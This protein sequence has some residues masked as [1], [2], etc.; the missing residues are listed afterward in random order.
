MK[1]RAAVFTGAGKP[2]EIREFPVSDPGPGAIIVRITTANICGSDLH[3]WKGETVL[4]LGPGPWILGHEMTGRI[5]R[6]GEGVKTDF[7]GQPLAEG[8]RVV[9]AYYRPCE[10]CYICLKGDRAACP[11]R[12]PSWWLSAEVPP[13]F[14]GAFAEYYYLMPG[15]PIFKVPDELSDDEVAPVNCALSQVIY[16]LHCVR[17][18]FGDTVIIQGAGGL[19]LYACAVAKEMGAGKVIAIDRLKNRLEAALAFGADET[20]SMEELPSTR[21]RLKRVRELT[22]GW[23]ADVVV[24][25]AGVAQAVTEGIPMLRMGGRYLWLGNISRGATAEIDLSTIVL[26][27]RKIIGVATYEAWAISKALDFLKRTRSRYPFHKLLSHKFKLEEINRA[28]EMA[29]KGEVT[30]AAVIP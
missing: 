16:G 20:I 17:I 14:N 19:G 9:Y 26:A 22:E 29:A 5:F 28:F 8:D 15:Q 23:G 27:N 25:V 10:R 4:G 7:T 30:R 24:E 1:G 18:E 12:F 2:M 21:D 6:L 13:H 3:I 11:Q